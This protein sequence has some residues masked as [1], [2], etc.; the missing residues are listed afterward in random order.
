MRAR[1]RARRSLAEATGLQS[2]DRIAQHTVLTFDV[3][4]NEI[5]GGLLSGATLVLVDEHKRLVG[6]ERFLVAQRITVLFI[7][8]SHLSL[9][10]AAKCATAPLRALAVAG[11]AVTAKLVARWASP[12]RAFLNQY[13]PT[14]ADVVSWH[15]CEP[16]GAAA[17]PGVTRGGVGASLVRS[18][19]P[20]GVPVLGAMLHIVGDGFRPVPVGVPGELLIAGPQLADGY[21]GHHDLTA[22]RFP[23]LP[24]GTRVYR[25]GDL[26][27][28]CPDGCIEYL[29]RIDRQVMLRQVHTTAT[30]ALALNW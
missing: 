15:Q 27:R 4:G 12:T 30:L 18:T 2:K 1:A 24:D 10:D 11:E 29:G 25:T 26:C 3:A 6:L 9:L 23:T 13:G 17:R 28:W 20:I 21:L 16:S 14:E 8:P 22:D 19:V 5:W 7:T